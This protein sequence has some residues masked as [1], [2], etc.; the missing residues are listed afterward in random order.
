MKIHPPIP[1][2]LPAFGIAEPPAP[3]QVIQELLAGNARFAKGKRQ[4]TLMWDEDTALRR[5]L[6]EEPQAPIA[7][8]LGCSDSRTAGNLIFDQE[9]GRLF[10]VQVAGGFLGPQAL[11]SIEFAVECLATPLVMVLSHTQCG[12]IQTLMGAGEQPL[13]GSL[14]A[15]QYEFSELM[16]QWPRR[17]G[18]GPAAY[19]ERLAMANAKRQAALLVEKSRTVRAL[20]R[21]GRLSVVPAIYQLET[22]RVRLIIPSVGSE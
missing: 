13:S 4:R 1:A 2:E 20:L 6:A 15:L 14:R 10:S 8:L 7:A 9:L 18:E 12:A 17:Q 21:K 22:G 19:S 11:A 16:S 3:Q 5:Q